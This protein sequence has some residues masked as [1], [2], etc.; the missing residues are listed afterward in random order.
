[1]TS[2]RY[3]NP[4]RRT[5]HF[6]DPRDYEAAVRSELDRAVRAR[7]RGASNLVGTQLSAGLDSSAVTATA[8]MQMSATASL[9]AYTSAP[10]ADLSLRPTRRHR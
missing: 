8:A 5:L 10:R 1:M 2:H 4:P 3:W 9:V 7:L 6:K